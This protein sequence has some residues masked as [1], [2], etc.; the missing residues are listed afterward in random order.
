MSLSQEE[1]ARALGEIDDARGKVA[2]LRIYRASSPYMILTGLGWLIADT[3][4]QFWPNNLVWPLTSLL[5]MT[6]SMAIGLRHR[7]E[8][9]PLTKGRGDWRPILSMLTVMVFTVVLFQVLW[10]VSGRQ[11]HA[12]FGLFT[13]FAY[14]LLGLWFGARLL[15]LGL[16]LA[17]ITLFAYLRIEDYYTLVMG[18]V[19]GGGL[20]LGGLWL[21]KV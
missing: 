16:A 5:L 19:G 12:V 10:P 20:I 11:V 17:A 2:R 7:H 4:F 14:I 21:R 13:A 3:V 6:G 8:M 18:L 15:A 9:K 1:A